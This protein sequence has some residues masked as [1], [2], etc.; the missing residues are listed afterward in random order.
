MK[1]KNVK[2]RNSEKLNLFVGLGIMLSAGI[3]ILEV[4]DSLL[5]D[6][7][8]G[9]KIFLETLRE[10]ISQGKKISSAMA[11]FPAIFDQVT[12]NVLRVAEES[13]TLETS[14]KEVQSTLQKEIK[15]RD[16]VRAA[17]LYPL[18]V[19]VVFFLVILV[20][21][22]FV[23]PRVASVFTALR[24]TLPLPTKIL[25][26]LSDSLRHQTL[27]VVLTLAIVVVGISVVYI[28]KRSWLMNKVAS[29][30]LISQIARGIDLTRLSRS[31]SLLLN[32][33]IPITTSLEL[34]QSVVVKE[35][36][37]R[38][39]V[40]LRETVA[41]GRKMSEGLKKSPKIIPKFMI[42]MTE[43]GE[44]SGSLENSMQYVSEYLE[45]QIEKTLATITTL[46]EPALL[47]VI[48]IVVGSIMLSIIGPIYSL[49]SQI[50]PK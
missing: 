10:D 49:I 4:V 36:V 20:V 21:L 45:Y 23:I 9:I 19:V 13:G 15:F 25:V 7:K 48:G 35:D 11:K 24:I 29:L 2:I 43:A 6:S 5:E 31:L 39:V 14:I 18:I 22:F 1:L 32:S 41:S 30:P 26:F 38:A 40:E 12:I 27:I 8:G 28:K 34:A 17:A 16:K 47:V 46:L 42:K 50:G 44:R 3:P 37:R 33:G